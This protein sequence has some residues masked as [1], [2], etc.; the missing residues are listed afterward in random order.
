[1]KKFLVALIFIAF[2]VAV[3]LVNTE[4]NEVVKEEIEHVKEEITDQINDNNSSLN[5]VAG[6]K[7]LDEDES[8]IGDSIS[9]D[10]EQS[11]EEELGNY[12]VL[13]SLVDSYIEEE[14]KKNDKG[15]EDVIKRIEAK[16][17]AYIDLL[18]SVTNENNADNQGR[19]IKLN[20]LRDE[21][22]ELVDELTTNRR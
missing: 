19:I 22:L 13:V 10:N 11:G 5:D 6:T 4:K 21:L 15:S 17:K 9:A 20:E 7:T 18:S 16:K 8:S 12:K 3:Y 1:M 2:G 14:V